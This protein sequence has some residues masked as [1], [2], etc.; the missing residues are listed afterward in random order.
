MSD[1]KLR[2]LERKAKTGDKMAE[3]LVKIYSNRAK[4]QKN[5]REMRFEIGG[6]LV[7]ESTFDTFTGDITRQ[8]LVGDMDGWYGGRISWSDNLPE[9][10]TNEWKRQFGTKDERYNN[11]FHYERVKAFSPVPETVDVAI[12]TYCGFGCNYCYMD[13][14]NKGTHMPLESLETIIKGFDQPPYQMAFGGGSPTSHPEFEEVLKLTRNLGVIPNYT[15]EGQNLTDKILDATQKYCGGV[16]LTYHAW[17]DFSYFKTAYSKLKQALPYK[18]INIHVICDKDVVENL[19]RLNSWKKY[20]SY[21]IVLLAFYSEVGRSGYGGMNKKTYMEKLPATIKKLKKAGHKFAISEGMI[22]YFLS[23]P[24]IGIDMSMATPI[25]GNFSCY[26]DVNG[27]MSHSSFSPLYSTDKKDFSEEELR[28]SAVNAS[29]QKL[30]LR[31]RS[32]TQ[33]YGSNCD[34]CQK[35]FQ[36]STPQEDHYLICKYAKHNDP[37]DRPITPER[38]YIW[39]REPVE[40]PHQITT[41]QGFITNSSSAIYHFD[42]RV[43]EHPKVKAFI[44][45]YEI[46]KGYVGSNLWYRSECDTFA[47]TTEQKQAVKKELESEEYYRETVETNS[48]PIVVFGDEYQELTYILGHVMRDASNE[49]GLNYSQS[50]YN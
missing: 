22:S 7:Y 6:K 44:E 38:D 48:G 43:L 21:N 32:Y 3:E 40:V 16:A 5:I 28:N 13:A 2:E 45:N 35:S 34:N 9:E 46:G 17:R 36:C 15:T 42:E 27:F 4:L 49:L 29:S 39:P 14:T 37:S 26:I 30:W 8:H 24:E 20:G 19:E 10:F 31:L 33:Q 18:Q 25:E 23:R 47:I 12:N 50:E 1:R 41:T 11:Y